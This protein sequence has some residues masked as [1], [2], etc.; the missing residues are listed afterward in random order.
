LHKELNGQPLLDTVIA[1]NQRF[2]RSYINP[3]ERQR[4]VISKS[5]ERNI[6]RINNEDLTNFDEDLPHEPFFSA[7]RSR[8][9]L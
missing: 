4:E 7:L 2:N 5:K 6:Q 1:Q 8:L 3:N 9:G